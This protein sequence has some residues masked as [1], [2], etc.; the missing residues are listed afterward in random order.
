MTSKLFLVWRKAGDERWTMNMLLPGG[1]VEWLMVRAA[2]A[3][4]AGE[5]AS[6]HADRRINQPSV[7]HWSPL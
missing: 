7:T 5:I 2:S 6:W 3:N 1:K 4:A